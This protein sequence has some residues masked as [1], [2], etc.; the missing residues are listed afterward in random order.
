M[1]YEKIASNAVTRRDGVSAEDIVVFLVAAAIV[2]LVGALLLASLRLYK[3]VRQAI[4]RRGELRR[5]R[6]AAAPA[7][8]PALE[9]ASGIALENLNP[10][11]QNQGA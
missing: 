4:R 3:M 6:Q 5:N 7:P 10:Q 2:V 8:S 9:E 11:A 1:P